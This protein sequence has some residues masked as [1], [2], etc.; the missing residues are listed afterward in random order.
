M[1]A[2]ELK[3]LYAGKSVEQKKRLSIGFVIMGVLL[4][5]LGFGAVVFYAFGF[6]P[7]AM[8]LAFFIIMAGGT[9]SSLG[10]AALKLIRRG[11][12]EVWLDNP[13]MNRRSWHE[14]LESNH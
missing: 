1:A 14:Q 11:N 8:T 7:I 9:I 3:K 6:H 2:N 13:F 5:T 12:L 4:L 10:F